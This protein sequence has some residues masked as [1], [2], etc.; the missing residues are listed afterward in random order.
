M[1]ALKEVRSFT[2]NCSIKK[3]FLLKLRPQEQKDDMA[4]DYSDEHSN[5]DLKPNI[6]FLELL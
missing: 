3:Y 5:L 2:G 6:K 4:E 1:L